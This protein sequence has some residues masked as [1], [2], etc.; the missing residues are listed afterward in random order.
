MPAAGSLR[1]VPI[2]SAP[3]HTH[4]R[5]SL[6]IPHHRRHA[7]FA[8]H[9]STISPDT[10]S[11]GIAVN[12]GALKYFNVTPTS[13]GCTSGSS[14]TTCTLGIDAAL[15]VDT[16]QVNTYSATSG[17]GTI[18]DQSAPITAD[19]LTG[20][21]NSVTIKLGP[22]VSTTADSG[23][24]SL[25]Y[26]VA[27]ASR[28]D[29]IA[30]LIPNGSTIVVLSPIALGNVTVAGPGFTH[31][32]STYGGIT[33]SGNKASQVFQVAS[34][35]TATISGLIVTQG[36]A[37]VPNQPGGALSNAGTLTLLQD[38]FVGNA[39]AEAAVQ[40]A[41]CKLYEGGAVYNAATLTVTDSTFDSNLVTSS[42]FTT[43]CVHGVGGAIF[44]DT[45]A[46]LAVT[47]S[48][49]TNNVAIQGGALY[50]RATSGATISADTFKANLGCNTAAAGCATN[51]CTGSGCTSYAL[52]YGAAIYDAYVASGKGITIGSSTFEN[53]VAGGGNGAANTT[54]A[55][56]GGALYLA[57]GRPVITASAFNG[58]AAGGGSTNCSLGVGG[59]IAANVPIEI[60][61]D[62]FTD[63]TAMGDY[64]AQAGAV[65]ENGG[66][67]DGLSDTF[68][69]N[70]ATGLGGTA[71]APTADAG[72]GG[73][74]A[75]TGAT[76]T[77]GT[78][79]T[80]TAT[81]TS[82][83]YG[84]AIF[85][86]A[87][88]T[89]ANVTF[90]QNSATANGN[91]GATSAVQGGAIL[92]GAALTLTSCTIA[93]NVASA[94][95][96]NAQAAQGGGVYASA[97]LTMSATTFTSNHAT[98]PT[99]VP[100]WAYGGAVYAAGSLTST[101]GH[102]TTN[103]ITGGFGASGGGIYAATTL[104][105]TNDGFKSNQA[106]AT[107]AYGG[108]LFADGTGTLDEGAFDSNSSGD[109]TQ[110]GVGGAI[111]DEGGIT[112]DNSTIT[113]NQASVAGGGLYIGQSD[114]LGADTIA[115]NQVGYATSSWGGGAIYNSN[116]T[117]TIDS[118]MIGNNTVQLV[119]GATAA[120]GGAI[121]VNGGMGLSQST[122]NGNAVDGSGA[123][124]GGGGVLFAV[125]GSIVNSTL[126]GN[127][128]QIDGAG[129][130][131]NTTGTVTLTNDTIDDNT[132]TGKGGN[133]YDPAGTLALANTILAHGYA[134]AASGGNDLNTSG[135]AL[136]DR[137]YNLIQYSVIGN[138][139]TGAHDITG[140]DPQLSAL[141]QNGGS[142]TTMSDANSPGK[143]YIP[144]AS[145][146]VS[147][148]NVTSSAMGVD[149]RG[150]H[151]GTGS[152]CDIGAYEY[153]ATGAVV[154]HVVHGPIPARA[155][156][157]DRRLKIAA[158]PKP[159]IHDLLRL[160][161]SHDYVSLRSG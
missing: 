120:G 40:P 127:T 110:T 35:V 144:F 61:N 97:A 88:S 155:A 15:G 36:N 25:R 2:R 86:G 54:S 5:L 70:A 65:Y 161:L 114:Y 26:A 116:G 44:N 58:N 38:A 42:P 7:A 125:G 89:F 37:A 63:N 105:S 95:G 75:P 80:N 32:G 101:N 69:S 113:N 79:G 159:R 34:G 154:R 148:G 112:I 66:I 158:P 60:D 12:G 19:I 9:P 55:G 76:L 8:T 129:V 43:P 72:G 119:S 130:L 124:N 82:N 14:G 118:S 160:R 107:L 151:R 138:A 139:L 126:Y 87:T 56:Y 115:G 46:T 103:T 6:T 140:Q 128:S 98:V 74:Y 33:V 50:N 100:A 92:A 13:A 93:A 84:G 78:F 49:F 1:A 133:V 121:Y 106:N 147:C 152:V 102:F 53:N 145:L 51:G 17:G 45:N 73:V 27:N 111:A 149:E 142:V 3:G 150:Y 137:D 157:P 134:G 21:A 117:M 81:G 123:G 30:F 94:L 62:T 143:G 48:T 132:A 131:Q 41:G 20:K 108:G 122:L 136:T 83:V 23:P 135:G 109:S 71:C 68:T 67:L 99:S 22:V 90:A 104:T 146:P 29:T 10:Q 28:G 85:T 64:G 59:A 57:A 16:F 39:S 153:A 77:G 47:G 96:T 4:V 31:T 141:A 24:G 156:H 52:G 91:N 11:V 18:L